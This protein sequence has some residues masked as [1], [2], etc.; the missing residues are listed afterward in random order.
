MVET[1]NDNALWLQIL[2]ITRFCCLV[3]FCRF[4]CAQCT[5]SLQWVAKLWRGIAGMEDL[6]NQGEACTKCRWLKEQH[7]FVGEYFPP[8]PARP[9]PASILVIVVCGLQVAQY[10]ASS[11]PSCLF[12]SKSCSLSKIITL[13]TPLTLQSTCASLQRWHGGYRQSWERG[14]TANQCRL[15]G[16]IPSGKHR[17]AI[18]CSKLDVNLVSGFWSVG[19]HAG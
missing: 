18:F 1:C 17:P 9:S 10:K 19:A 7:I 12:S 13:R 14:V 16:L 6:L 3:A 11:L 4:A 8:C 2:S 15:A 5:L